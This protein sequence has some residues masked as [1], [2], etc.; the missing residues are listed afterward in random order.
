MNVLRL[1]F[2]LALGILPNVSKL[3]AQK[4]VAGNDSGKVRTFAVIIGITDYQNPAIPALK[5]PD[6]DAQQFAAYLQSKAGGQVADTHIKLLVNKEATIAA[7]YE[8]LDWL[9]E[10]CE[11]DDV[12]YIY[13]SGHGDV[14]TKNNFSKGYLLAYNSPQNNYAN[15]AIRVEDINNTSLILTTKNKAKVILISDACHS[16]KL[17]G[18]FFKGKQLASGQLRL[19]LN[20]QVRLASCAENEEA[21]EGPDWGGGRGVFSYYLVMGLQGLADLR[22]DNS[23]QLRDLSRY[24]DSSFAADQVL[25]QNKHNQHPVTDGNPFYPMANI[26][27]ATLNSLKSD[28]GNNDAKR[29]NLPAGLM[30]LKPLQPQPIDYF[31]KAV[32]TL[33]LESFLNFDSYAGLE[34]AALPSK[35]VDDCIAYQKNLY[36]I[37]DTTT[38]PDVNSRFI[39]FFNLDTLAILR[40]DLLENKSANSRFVEKFVQMVQEKGQ[41]M[42]NAYLKGDLDELEKRQYYYS[43]N[44]D[45]R[46]FISML[47]VAIK[48]VPE[49]HQLAH[50]LQVHNYYLTGLIDR[51]EMS[52]TKNTD[53]LLARAFY[54]QQQAL[55]LE[56]Y[57][58][59]ILNELGNLYL[60]KNNYDSARYNFNLASVIS[61][62]WAIPWSNKIRL[63]LAFNK[64]DEAER[65]I[66]TAD[67]L[68]PNLA[69]VYINAGLVM[70]KKKNLLAAE[71]YYLRAIKENS[72]HYLPFER[73]GNLYLNTGRFADAN[74]YLY[75][76]QTRK[77][78]FAVNDKTFNYG[79]E[80]GG[81]GWNEMGARSKLGCPDELPATGKT[82]NEYIQLFNGLEKLDVTL[83]GGDALK[84]LTELVKQNPVIPLAYHYLGKK[85]YHLGQWQ[86][87]RESLEKAARGY[88][89]DDALIIRLTKDI[90]GK[91][92]GAEDSCKIQPF[93]YYQYDV[94]ED[95]YMLGAIYEKTGANAKA[96]AEY[97]L[98]ASIEN[99]RLMVQATYQNYSALV[100]SFRG[101]DQDLNNYLTKETEETIF[102]GGAIKAARLH[103]KLGEFAKAE[104]VLLAQVAHSRAAGNARRAAIRAKK[105][106]WNVNGVGGI[107]FYWLSANSYLECETYNFYKNVLNRFPRD[108]EWQEKAGLFL[109]HRL[110]LAFDQAAV[111]Q[112][113]PFYESISRFAYPWRN[114]VEQNE[115]YHFDIPGTGDS[116]TIAMDTYDPVK[117]SR[118]A[119]DLSVKLSG[120]IKPHLVA[121]KALSDLYAW[122]GNTDQ[123]IYW[124]KQSISLNPANAAQRNKFFNYLSAIDRLPAACDQLDTL[125]Q[126]KKI[127]SDQTLQLAD[128]NMLAGKNTKGK[129]ILIKFAPEYKDQKRA[130]LLLNARTSLLA[131]DTKSALDILLNPATNLTKNKT[132]DY[133]T[134]ADKSAQV[135]EQLYAIARLYALLDKHHLAFMKLTKA[136]DSGFN[137]NYVLDND[138]AWMKFRDTDQWKKLISNYNYQVYIFH[139]DIDP[140]DYRIPEQAHHE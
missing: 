2:L 134:E 34:A 25:A 122:S 124:F 64:L 94:L 103:E 52:R 9:K 75:Q 131:G 87:A 127:T 65:D 93:L 16:G 118:N 8:S 12:A 112:Y 85:Y 45:Y 136:L 86:L 83:S 76:A 30:A 61:P 26:D 113:K 97:K 53:S 24:L 36:L 133:Q 91:P 116:I 35:M 10:Q 31:F 19:V 125:Y 7:I 62:T 128:W 101:F 82:A 78:D 105:A 69:Y 54:Q 68:Q 41:D 47:H 89:S 104:E 13:F 95:H 27:A 39:D 74:Y 38:D 92:L 96:F 126:Q 46:K 130:V 50:I 49:S 66:H 79:V 67:S 32:S 40:K 132:D 51:L 1:F 102:M 109:Y 107:N 58:A 57:A 37:R 84:L 43:G 56:P 17:A 14:E 98:I 138:K 70:E 117:F 23:I 42:I 60:H 28:I 88:L 140:I 121:A 119:I 21:A 115:D 5:Y 137:Y 44:R 81:M 111:E 120:D 11:K 59:Y 55:K 100:K 29:S 6:K 3:V 63:N 71:S 129:K 77:K 20:N 108:P 99:K 48:L 18:D 90:F 22:K 139:K 15:N 135:N 114:G 4:M 123:A 33:A 72:V 110:A 106:G 73:L 80:L